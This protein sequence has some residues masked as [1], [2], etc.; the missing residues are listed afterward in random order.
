[1]SLAHFFSMGLETQNLLTCIQYFSCHIQCE[2]GLAI[3]KM[4]HRQDLCCVNFLCSFPMKQPIFF[5][6]RS[7]KHIPWLSTFLLKVQK[8]NVC[9]LDFFVSVFVFSTQPV[10]LG[11]SGLFM[12]AFCWWLHKMYDIL[13]QARPQLQK[14]GKMSSADSSEELSELTVH[15]YTPTPAPSGNSKASVVE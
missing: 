6:V 9:F 10:T 8:K 14:S 13:G 4:Y 7:L 5:R 1:M 3:C 2:S 15:L 11:Q 12:H